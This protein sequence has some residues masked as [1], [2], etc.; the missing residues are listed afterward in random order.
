MSRSGEPCLSRHGWKRTMFSGAF[1]RT[2]TG[3]ACRHLQDDAANRLGRAFAESKPYSGSRSLGSRV[4]LR[5]LIASQL[6]LGGSVT[7]SADPD[8]GLNREHPA[9]ASNMPVLVVQAKIAVPPIPA[10]A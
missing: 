4:I 10:I 3:T 6:R 2:L 8:Q 9:T 7:A 5:S 1:T